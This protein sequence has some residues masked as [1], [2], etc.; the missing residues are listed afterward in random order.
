MQRLFQRDN[1]PCSFSR[2]E[3]ASWWSTTSPSHARLFVRVFINRNSAAFRCTSSVLHDSQLLFLN[4]LSVK[5]CCQPCIK[6]FRDFHG[7]AD[8]YNVTNYVQDLKLPRC[9]VV[10]GHCV[11]TSHMFLEPKGLTCK[12]LKNMMS[13]SQGIKRIQS[14][15]S[16]FRPELIP[17]RLRPQ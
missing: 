13:F 11:Y 12:Q 14:Y 7:G 1:N 10:H 9:R 4:L 16:R 15:R 8:Q 6:S 5:A 17:Q 2:S 3:L